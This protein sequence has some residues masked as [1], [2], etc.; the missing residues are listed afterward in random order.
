MSTPSLVIGIDEAGRGPV[1]GDMFVACVALEPHAVRELASRGV[2]DSKALDRGRRER[3]FAY[4]ITLARAVAVARATPREIDSTNL[5]TLFIE[6][7][8]TALTKVLAA[9]SP[10][11]QIEVFID[12]AGDPRRVAASIERVAKGFC[13]SVRVVAEHGADARYTVVG[14]ASIVAKVLR[15]WHVDKLK[16]VYGDFGS[17]YP[18][19]PRTR[20]WLERVVR[21]GRVPPIVRRSW[22]TYKRIASR[23]LLD[24]LDKRG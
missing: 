13:R 1:V 24:Y 6:K 21:S 16:R 11:E 23:T 12:A 15:D 2:R 4:V 19:D 17:G 22:G 7:A 18:A 3:L 9:C 8:C 10:L 5:N 14:A 20:E